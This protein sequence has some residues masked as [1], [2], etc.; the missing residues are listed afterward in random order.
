MVV[1]CKWAGGWVGKVRTCLSF[2]LFRIF[3]G[4][5]KRE[6]ERERETEGGGGGR[7]GEYDIHIHIQK[8]NHKTH[9]HVK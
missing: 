1:Y 5:G 6:N 4:N 3:F 9:R 2:F 8:P 7:R